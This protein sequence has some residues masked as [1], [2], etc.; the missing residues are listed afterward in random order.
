MKL[1]VRETNGDLQQIKVTQGMKFEPS[2]GQ[3]FYFTGATE[4][5][6]VLTD[7]DKSIQLQL[8]SVDGE[9]SV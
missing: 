7:R 9:K 6:T 5:N 2:E 4:F 8:T 1:I 3:Q